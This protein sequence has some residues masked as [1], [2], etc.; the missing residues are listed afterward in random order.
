[1]DLS[2]EGIMHAKQFADFYGINVPYNH[3]RHK[4]HK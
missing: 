1:M 2:L 3:S 4:Y